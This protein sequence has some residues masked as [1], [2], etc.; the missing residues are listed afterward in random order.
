MYYINLKRLSQKTFWN[1][2]IYIKE[3]WIVSNALYNAFYINDLTKKRLPLNTLLYSDMY[4]VQL[5]VNFTM[6]CTL[7]SDVNTVI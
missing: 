4:T 7:Y 2:K 5:Y 3:T 6:M 1:L